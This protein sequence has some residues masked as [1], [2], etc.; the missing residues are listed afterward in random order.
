MGGDVVGRVE[1]DV[2]TVQ[3]HPQGSNGEGW[4]L[5]SSPLQGDE[6]GRVGLEQ[7]AEDARFRG[8]HWSPEVMLKGKSRAPLMRTAAILSGSE[9]PSSSDGENS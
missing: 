3:L 9:D 7:V 8:L 4:K 1:A 2:F 6:E 5:Y